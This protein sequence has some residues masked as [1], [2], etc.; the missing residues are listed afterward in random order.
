VSARSQWRPADSDVTV[1]QAENS[2][3]P[4]C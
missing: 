3:G 1:H 4:L 2:G